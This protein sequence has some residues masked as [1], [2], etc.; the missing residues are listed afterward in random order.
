MDW[1]LLAKVL[2]KYDH[3]VLKKSWGGISAKYKVQLEKLQ[4][5][6]QVA[7]LAAY[8]KGDVPSINYDDLVNYDWERLINWAIKNLETPK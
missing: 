7:F 3:E 5:D 2:K 4:S 6:F 1:V 8:R